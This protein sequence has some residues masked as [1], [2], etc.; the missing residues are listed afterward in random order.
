VEEQKETYGDQAADIP[1]I[2]VTD[3]VNVTVQPR[4]YPS[5]GAAFG[6]LGILLGSSLVAGFSAGVVATIIPDIMSA[7]ILAGYVIS[8]GLSV[9]L[10]IVF[11]GHA[12]FHLSPGKAVI[13]LLVLLFT[14]LFIVIR[15]PLLYLI[16]SIAEYNDLYSDLEPA[17]VFSFLLTVIAAPLLEELLF[18]GIILDG[19]LKRYSAK[20]SIILSA[21]LFGIAHLNPAQF[22]N[23]FVLGLFIG[24]IFWRTRSLWLCIFIHLLNNLAAYLLELYV[25]L[26]DGLSLRQMFGNDIY[27][28][29]GYMA[30]LLVAAGL[31]MAIWA[32]LKNNKA[33]ADMA[34][35]PAV[36]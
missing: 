30:S 35:E 9:Y 10:G 33:N 29:L 25:P 16:S 2:N 26:N 3:P 6:L 5:V 19:F 18:R 21:L 36:E 23:G 17:S 14:P 11:R 7:C 1:V 20:R 27:Y 28:V 22:V 15:L 31:G 13:W 8:F 24:W 12:R 32:L 34:P 4:P